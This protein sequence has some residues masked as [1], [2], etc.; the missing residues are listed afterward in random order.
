L[1]ENLKKERKDG[2]FKF[3][4]IHTEFLFKEWP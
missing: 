4:E 1:T 2:V 3:G